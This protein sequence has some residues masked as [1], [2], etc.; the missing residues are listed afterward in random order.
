MA[1]AAA[2]VIDGASG[3]G[4]GGAAAAAAAGCPVSCCSAAVVEGPFSC[5]PDAANLT[6]A[7]AAEGP[8]AAA[9]LLLISWPLVLAHWELASPA[10]AYGRCCWYAAGRV[11]P[12]VLLDS[13]MLLKGL[14]LGEGLNAGPQ[15]KGGTHILLLLVLP[16]GKGR[17]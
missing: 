13:S 14:G 9:L 6:A 1:A 11:A 12:I 8:T 17:I 16:G 2:A 10:D 4:R 15:P 7:A 3:K 5:M